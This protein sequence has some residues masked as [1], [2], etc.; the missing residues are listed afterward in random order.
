MRTFVIQ[1]KFCF[2]NFKQNIDFEVPKNLSDSHKFIINYFKNRILSEIKNPVNLLSSWH[3][4]HFIKKA[5]NNDLEN[6]LSFYANIPLEI[7]KNFFDELGENLNGIEFDKKF[8]SLRVEIYAMDYFSKNGFEILEKP[9]QENGNCDLR[10]SK[11]GQ[12]YN[13]EVKGKENEDVSLDRL[14]QIYDAYSSFPNY[15]FLRGKWL[16]IGFLCDN[17]NRKWKEI[18]KEVELSLIGL[19]EQGEFKGDYIQAMY[20]D[21][22]REIKNRDL[23]TSSRNTRG[24][25]IIDDLD[26]KEK[27]KELICD[28]FVGENRKLSEIN[29]KSKKFENFIGFL[30]WAVPFKKKPNCEAIRDTFNEVANEIN[31]D[32]DLYVCLNYYYSFDKNQIF[33]IGRKS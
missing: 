28:L 7:L 31:M 11:D 22:S 5:Q 2:E 23:E 3:F 21:K 19:K 9:K 1:H 25:C 27:I 17:P 32:F 6:F 15:S 13:V 8:A 12:I 24:F 18:N 33:K 20:F 26:D 30:F 4:A 29:D 10:M 14:G 16:N